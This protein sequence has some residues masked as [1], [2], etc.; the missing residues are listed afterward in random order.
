MPVYHY[1]VLDSHGHKHS[2]ILEAYSEKEAKERLRVQGLMVSKLM[3]RTNSKSKE[4]LKGEAL[5]GFTLQ[6][7]Q[8]VSAGVPL[9]ESLMSIEELYRKEPSHR[10]IVSICEQIKAGKTF[11]EALSAYPSSFDKLY[12]A[13]VAAGEAVG[14]L[15]LVLEKLSYFLSRQIKLNGEIVTAMIYPSILGCFALVVISLLLGFVVPSIEGIFADRE[16]NG[17]TSF[18]LATSHFVRNWWWIY[19]PLGLGF[20]AFAFVK[21]RSPQGHLWMQRTLLKMPLIKNVVIQSALARFC[22]TMGT[23]QLGGMTIIDSLRIARGVMKNVVLEEEIQAAEGKIIEGSSL[24]KQLSRSAYIPHMVT[25]MIAVGED[26]G[27]SAE[28]FNRIAD[29]YEDNVEKTLA[30]TVA[31]V[32]PVILVVMGGVIGMVMIAILLPLTDIASFAGG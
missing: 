6:L 25:R 3:V 9:Y 10:I 31:L 26:S 4:R 15:D 32:Q 19:L 24:S 1:Q 30:R 21:L 20:A 17:F 28:M 14:A 2:G 29:I 16:L 23:L 18:V 5:M 8:L 11:S 22:R 13:M 7:S 27:S 12:C